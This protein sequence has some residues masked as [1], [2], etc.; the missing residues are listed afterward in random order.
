MTFHPEALDLAQLKRLSKQLQRGSKEVLPNTPLTLA[1]SQEL[2]A[3]TLGYPSW[4]GVREERKD[5]KKTS[6]TTTAS[7]RG[8]DQL[9]VY[10]R[11]L[12]GAFIS[13]SQG[14]HGDGIDALQAI[15]KAFAKNEM[16]L[17]GVAGD[18]TQY[19]VDLQRAL[20]N[21]SG[22]IGHPMAQGDCTEPAAEVLKRALI[23]ARRESIVA[24]ALFLWLK[25]VDEPLWSVLHQTGRAQSE[26]TDPFLSLNARAML[27]GDLTVL[28]D[29]N[30]SF[31]DAIKRVADI[32]EAHHLAD[33]SKALR[34]EWIPGIEAVEY[35][36]QFV[37]RKLSVYDK[38]A[39]IRFDLVGAA[40][41]AGEALRQLS[42][43]TEKEADRSD[44]L[45]LM[46]PTVVNNVA[47]PAG[48]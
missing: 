1:Q 43:A 3:R 22:W 28:V 12:L 26:Q 37:S 4:H 27:W 48:A 10:E 9:R 25:S 6:G 39:A 42:K 45:R 24:S 29:A 14:R 21:A 5:N 18:T 31:L 44:Y 7:W 17:A 34:E 23:G 20:D 19:P 40:G 33:R 41:S 8:V 36:Q 30:F 38:R 16:D 47:E 2:L 13:I 32:Y 46:T 11:V 15:G 35:W